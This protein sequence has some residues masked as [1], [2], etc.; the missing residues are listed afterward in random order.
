MA[1]REE[2]KT[3]TVNQ[4]PVKVHVDCKGEQTMG[5]RQQPP[6]K[7][8]GSVRNYKCRKCGRVFK[9]WYLPEE[10]R[11]CTRCAEHKGQS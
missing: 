8:Y 1:P 7:E 6:Q 2:V 4:K 11:V 9:D 3:I 5:Y 10:K